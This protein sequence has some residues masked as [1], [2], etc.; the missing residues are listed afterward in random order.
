MWRV[1]WALAC[2]FSLTSVVAYA[3]DARATDASEHHNCEDCVTEGWGWCHNTRKCG[4]FANTKCSGTVTDYERSRAAQKR[5]LV[6][7]GHGVH[8]MELDMMSL[9]ETLNNHPWVLVH[10]YSSSDGAGRYDMHRFVAGSRR[11]TSVRVCV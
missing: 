8:L 7:H 11:W 3:A 1:G 6:E 9:T 10:F 2:W 4:G 5:W